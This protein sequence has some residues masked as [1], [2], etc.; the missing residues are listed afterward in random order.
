MSPNIVRYI[1]AGN[2][3]DYFHNNEFSDSF[4]HNQL[5]AS[6]SGKIYASYTTNK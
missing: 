3:P 5:I 2:M 6:Y 4:F 1:D